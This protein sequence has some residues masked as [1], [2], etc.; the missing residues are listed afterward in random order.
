MKTIKSTDIVFATVISRGRTVARVTL[1]GMTSVND[2][3][4]NLSQR[5][6]GLKGLMTLQLRNFTQGWS[7][8]SALNLSTVAVLPQSRPVQ[9]TL[10]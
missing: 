10:F 7:S 1:S 4:L 8:R 6:A 2:V 5:L 9:L 3:M